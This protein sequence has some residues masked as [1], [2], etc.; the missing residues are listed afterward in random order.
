MDNRVEYVPLRV[1]P[2]V[3]NKNVVVKRFLM[4]F[5][6]NADKEGYFYYKG[7]LK[8]IFRFRYA[9]RKA[10][11]VLTGLKLTVVIVAIDELSLDM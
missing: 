2:S 7:A 1:I 3:L 4:E 8:D 11:N 6:A 5:G 9:L 10:M